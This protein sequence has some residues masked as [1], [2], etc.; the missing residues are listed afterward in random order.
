[1]EDG[2]VFG[3]L[4]LILNQKRSATITSMTPTEVIEIDKNGFR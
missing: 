2:E 3:E 4:A 1:M